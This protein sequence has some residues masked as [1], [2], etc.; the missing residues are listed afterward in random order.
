MTIIEIIAWSCVGAGVLVWVVVVLR[1][2]ALLASIDL[3]QVRAARD[4]LVKHDIVEARLRR[5]FSDSSDRILGWVRPSLGLAFGVFGRLYRYLVELE[6][7]YRDR[8][9]HVERKGQ[10][11]MTQKNTV[12]ELLSE[13]SKKFDDEAYTDAEKMYIEAISLDPK[14]A[15][16]YRG[17][18]RVYMN[19]KNMRHARASLAH[20]AKV[21][22]DDADT[23]S[24]LAEIYAELEKLS[25]AVKEIQRAVDLQP[26]NPKYLDQATELAIRDLDV[27]LAEKMLSRLRKA[28]P[29]NQ[30][31]E[32]YENKILEMKAKKV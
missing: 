10:D 15:E 24:T 3:S 8:I 16:A 29:D 31:V 7:H 14:N 21:D 5:K 18:G 22:P 25:Q 11:V 30:K 19:Q 27:Y 17:L 13:A 1:K 26:N 32:E 6:H 12:M 28:N 4:M 20:A 23:H 9:Q 2:R